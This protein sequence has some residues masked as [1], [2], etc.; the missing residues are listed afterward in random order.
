MTHVVFPPFR[1][2]QLVEPFR[3]LILA[4]EAAGPKLLSVQFLSPRAP[5]QQVVQSVEYDQDPAIPVSLIWMGFFP[6]N[7]DVAGEGCCG[8][9]EVRPH[10]GVAA[11]TTIALEDD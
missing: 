1:L 6:V 11:V 8:Y 2:P 4:L 3:I 10:I 7:S 5:H 9:I